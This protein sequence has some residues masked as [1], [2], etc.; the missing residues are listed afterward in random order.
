MTGFLIFFYTIHEHAY[1]HVTVYKTSD[2]EPDVSI[3]LLL[4]QLPIISIE[5]RWLCGACWNYVE[6]ASEDSM[7]KLDL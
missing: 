1:T 7:A 2:I 5:Y 6:G 4:V 3:S